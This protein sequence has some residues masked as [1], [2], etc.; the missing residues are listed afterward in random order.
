VAQ[1][2]LSHIILTDSRLGIPLAIAAFRESIEVLVEALKQDR[3]KGRLSAAR[4]L[5]E[6]LIC[7]D[8]R[9][10]PGYVTKLMSS[11]FPDLVAGLLVAR[12]DPG[13]ALCT[14]AATTV[15]VFFR[16][17]LQT[18]LGRRRNDDFMG[19]VTAL[20]RYI[21]DN[22][23]HADIATEVLSCILASPDI[24]SPRETSS[25]LYSCTINTLAM[26]DRLATSMVNGHL[27]QRQCAFHLAFLLYMLPEKSGPAS[28]ISFAARLNPSIIAKFI[29]ATLRLI[30]DEG[31]ARRESGRG[32]VAGPAMLW[33]GM[34]YLLHLISL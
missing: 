33:E 12:E 29:P 19:I 20:L 7:A 21:E 31:N 5:A 9:K 16:Q 17:D 1:L 32:N 2:V 10:G 22:G 23:E 8:D 4:L 25:T 6:V 15:C 14:I 11:E 30:E 13:L 28:N 26:S 34:Y 18:P 24:V 27:I 3:S